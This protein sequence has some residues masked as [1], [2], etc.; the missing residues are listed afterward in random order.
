MMT[1]VRALSTMDP[2]MYVQAEE[3]S[4]TVACP[5]TGTSAI[6]L[7]NQ[8]VHVECR[9]N[10]GRRESREVISV[11]SAQTQLL[12]CPGTDGG[13]SEAGIPQVSLLSY[14]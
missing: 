7:E 4:V 8:V 5:S 3:A 12:S 6:C 13:H 11:A 2:T 14:V 1:C 10:R 9:E